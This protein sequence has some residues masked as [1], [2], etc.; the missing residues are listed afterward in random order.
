MQSSDRSL[1]RYVANIT[2]CKMDRRFLNL[3][4]IARWAPL[5]GETRSTLFASSWKNSFV[6]LECAVSFVCFFAIRA[7]Q[8][9]QK[10]D[11]SSADGW[12]SRWPKVALRLW[13]WPWYW[14]QHM[15][16]GSVKDVQSCH[17]W[18]CRCWYGLKQNPAVSVLSDEKSPFSK[19]LGDH[20]LS[21][22]PTSYHKD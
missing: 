19:C 12:T 18:S 17:V 20:K 11:L 8:I 14:D 4:A 16:A 6:R 5:E 2:Y 13:S 9:G 1:C 3:E 15:T 22:I 21:F 10:C 7:T